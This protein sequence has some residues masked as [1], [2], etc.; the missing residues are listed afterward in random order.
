M[1]IIPNAFTSVVLF[2]LVPFLLLVRKGHVLFRPIFFSLIVAIPAIVMIDTIAHMTE[3]WLIPNSILTFRLF[4]FVTLEVV[5]WAVL[6]FSLFL[7]IWEN[8]FLLSKKSKTSF[9]DLNKII[10][11]IFIIVLF[12]L[13][14]I[15][16]QYLQEWKYFYASYGT[17][18]IGIPAFI[19]FFRKPDLQKNFLILTAMNILLTGTYEA[20]A[21]VVGWWSFP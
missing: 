6:N 4:H 8:Y 16:R 11:Y 19:F 5:L 14:L 20:V 12:L 1:G 17:I 7:F 2:F 18:L 13:F 3:Q 15:F 9:F 21:L 10:A